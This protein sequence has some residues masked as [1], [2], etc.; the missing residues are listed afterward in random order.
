[1]S[2]RQWLAEHITGFHSS[3]L[4]HFASWSALAR[5]HTKFDLPSGS[6]VHPIFHVSQLK[7]STGHHPVSTS[8]PSELAVFH[9][10]ERILQR[11]CTSGDHLVE[12]VFIKW[13][14]MLASLATWESVDHLREQFPLVPA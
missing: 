11:R 14:H 13:S 1:M 2:S 5:L 3:F 10:P 9:V 7:K 12:Q 8:L 6:S 4:G